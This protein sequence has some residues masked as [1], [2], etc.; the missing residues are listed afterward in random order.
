[1]GM[2]HAVLNTAACPRNLTGVNVTLCASVVVVELSSDCINNILA[3]RKMGTSGI[4]YVM[5]HSGTLVGSSD[6][7]TGLALTQSVLKASSIG[8]IT[9]NS[10]EKLAD[11]FG[12]YD[13]MR[14][15]GL[16]TTTIKYDNQN[17]LTM[18]GSITHEGSVFTLGSISVSITSLSVHGTPLICVNALPASDY[19]AALFALGIIALVALIVTLV[20]I[21]FVTVITISSWDI[22]WCLEKPMWLPVW[23]PT[24]YNGMTVSFTLSFVA[25]GCTIIILLT[26]AHDAAVQDLASQLTSSMDACHMVLMARSQTMLAQSVILWGSSYNTT[27]SVL[28]DINSWIPSLFHSQHDD[29][30]SALS[31]GD[32]S[33]ALRS[34]RRI[35]D[36]YPDGMCLFERDPMGC[37]VVS[38]VNDGACNSTIELA[39]P[40]NCNY[41]PRYTA[42]SSWETGWYETGRIGRKLDRSAVRV[43]Y[44]GNIGASLVQPVSYETRHLSGVWAVD[45]DVFTLAKSMKTLLGGIPGTLFVTD[46]NGMLFAASAGDTSG[47][48]SGVSAGNYDDNCVNQANNLILSEF[49]QSYVDPSA[50]PN[51]ASILPIGHQ[52]VALLPS[53]VA[54]NFVN[55]MCLERR[56]LYFNFDQGLN[57]A[58]IVL[59]FLSL[60]IIL[61]YNR[62]SVRITFHRRLREIK[63]EEE[64]DEVARQREER[65]SL[66]EYR[67]EDDEDVV[68]EEEE[69][70]EDERMIGVDD[71]DK[72]YVLNLSAVLARKDGPLEMME[73][74]HTENDSVGFVSASSVD[75]DLGDEDDLRSS[76]QVNTD[77]LRRD[78]SRRNLTGS[79][80]SMQTT[81]H[82][83]L[84]LANLRAALEAP[85]GF[86][87]SVIA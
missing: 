23:F 33:G 27:V 76:T 46:V 68:E 82:E 31:F 66:R 15:A 26:E 78:A 80:T 41:D 48:S 1:M 29:Q 2:S 77:N 58:F 86:E 4:T 36:D 57:V 34:V 62:T 37:V 70:E 69:E 47:F 17:S 5:D 11:K 28:D 64:Q 45:F 84:R 85:E 59:V 8:G 52:V 71:D 61:I 63:E 44:N 25:M 73:A 6:A 54:P 14:T 24:L 18:Q 21:T 72:E 19:G 39:K 65:K 16:G 67:N 83:K 40:Q 10:F 9:S 43:L 53:T 7:N 75:D 81:K 35:K 3:R 79:M 38:A 32:K 13:A 60:L 51:D 56:P 74:V 87:A 20:I 30:I 42:T 22:T 55:V 12:D 49:G 50:T